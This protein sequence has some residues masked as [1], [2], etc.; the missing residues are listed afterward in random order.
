MYVLP[1]Y[2]LANPT[3]H[4]FAPPPFRGSLTVIDGERAAPSTG[5]GSVSFTVNAVAP[6]HGGVG[7]A[8]PFLHALIS[9]TKKKIVFSLN[10]LDSGKSW[11]IFYCINYRLF[12]VEE[13]NMKMM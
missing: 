10:F 9:R 13:K 11:V 4:A 8:K 12:S 2:S 3:A 7:S 1:I 5:S 6:L